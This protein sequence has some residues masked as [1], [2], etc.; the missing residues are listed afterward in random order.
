MEV[1]DVREVAK[2]LCTKCYVCPIC[3]GVA[4]KGQIPGMG[5]KASGSTFIRNVAKLRDVKVVIDVI[6]DIDEADTRTSLFGHR[7][8]LPVYVAPIAGITNNS[9]AKMSELQYNQAIIHGAKQAGTIGFSGD[10]MNPLMF[11]EPLDLIDELDGWGIP[12]MKPWQK[13]GI[14]QR[15]SHIKEKKC[16]ALAMD[17]DSAGL[18]LLRSSEVKVENKSIDALKTIKSTV[19]VPFI[20]KGIM[21]VAGA[22]KAIEAGADGIVVSNHGGRVQDEACATI[23]VLK[24]IC[25]VVD[26]RIPVL[27]DGG[28]RSGEDV[29]KALAMGADGVLIGRPMMIAAIGGQTQ[30][31]ANALLKIKNEL[32][33][34]M[35]MSGCAN[36]NEIT[37]DKIRIVE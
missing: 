29:F 36:L 16:I 26:G 6:A 31:V 20:V 21:S 4:C 22:L 27:V 18:P 11:S 2:E 30:G 34:T 35:I 37:Y 28:F 14:D 1:K 12:T 19:E 5:G 7:V 17:I 25:D 10:G 33:Q 23:E 32:A 13:V 24:E 8:S 15:L 9:G 3:N